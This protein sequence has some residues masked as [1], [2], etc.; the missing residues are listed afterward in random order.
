MIKTLTNKCLADMQTYGVY[1]CAKIFRNIAAV[2]VYDIVKRKCKMFWKKILSNEG[3][4]C[5]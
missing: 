4:M 3:Q 5:L 1:V 2:I